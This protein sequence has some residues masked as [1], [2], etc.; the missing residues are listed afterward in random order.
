[1]QYVVNIDLGYDL[2]IKSFKNG[3]S[4]K[5]TTDDLT[6]NLHIIFSLIVK[7]YRRRYEIMEQAMEQFNYRLSSSTADENLTK[8]Q[9]LGLVGR[10]MSLSGMKGR[11]AYSYW[12]EEGVSTYNFN[13]SKPDNDPYS[14]LKYC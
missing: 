8:L 1:M 14:A 2:I 9:T 5:Y 3:E 11:P 6:F 7:G 13:D 4:K 10:N 12:L